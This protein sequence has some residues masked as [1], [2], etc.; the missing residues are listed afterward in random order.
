M[1]SDRFGTGGYD[2]KLINKLLWWS[3]TYPY[4]KK[5]PIEYNIHI[6]KILGN[7]RDMYISAD[8]S[9]WKEW[10]NRLLTEMML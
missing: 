3:I 8:K 10:R 7:I 1:P 6:E 9:H 4:Y 2:N 5:A